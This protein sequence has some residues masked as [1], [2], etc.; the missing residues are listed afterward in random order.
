[1]QYLT[2]FLFF[3]LCTY[4]LYGQNEVS[5]EP[6]ALKS[7][8]E[9]TTVT[10]AAQYNDS[11]YLFSKNKRYIYFGENLFALNVADIR[12]EFFNVFDT[13]HAKLEG[14]IEYNIK[15]WDELFFTNFYF[16][17][18]GSDIGLFA[19]FVIEGYQ[20]DIGIPFHKTFVL[21][22]DPNSMKSKKLFFIQLPITEPKPII[23]KVFSTPNT[24]LTPHLYADV[25]YSEE[26]LLPPII[27]LATPTSLATAF[28][29][30]FQLPRNNF[31]PI[32][33][34]LK[35][36]Y[37]TI[38]DGHNKHLYSNGYEI[39]DMENLDIF[40]VS[41]DSSMILSPILFVEGKPYVVVADI[42]MKRMKNTNYRYVS[43]SDA[44][45]ERTL[46]REK[47]PAIYVQNLTGNSYVGHD[48][49]IGFRNID[50]KPYLV[51]FR[52]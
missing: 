51:K 26:T 6:L 33:Q 12:M 39:L 16:L 21:L 1:M 4:A 5:V 43:V 22:F 23:R 34:G 31:R 27:G 8:E 38:L 48:V 40:F 52:P 30:T 37:S 19:D 46:S 32:L 49:Q 45:Q 10:M 28:P 35:F 29:P 42:D 2:T 20:S 47:L 36:N 9:M 18:V 14:E 44:K 7:G 3:L 17:K 25:E 11:Y 41:P 50:N 15:S 13:S 24:S